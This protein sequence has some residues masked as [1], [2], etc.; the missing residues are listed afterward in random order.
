MSTMNQLGLYLTDVFFTLALLFLMLRL[1]LGIAR[2]NFYNPISQTIVTLTDPL[3]L[4]LRKILPPIGRF[5]TA[6]LVL[7]LALKV[8]HLVILQY[9]LPGGELDVARLIIKAV[10]NLVHLAVMIYFFAIIIMVVFSWLSMAGINLPPQLG[11]VIQSLLHPILLPIRKVMPNLG[12]L[13]LSPMVAI[14]IIGA[15]RIVIRSWL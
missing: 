7:L 15:I 6:L 2:A 11:S 8:L 14:V 4:P 13:D 10:A 3:V 9:L 5:D 12:M 1:L